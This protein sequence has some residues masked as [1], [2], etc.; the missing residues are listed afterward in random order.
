MNKI[1]VILLLIA[2]VCVI[3][4]LFLRKRTLYSSDQ[5]FIGTNNE[6]Q[7]LMI[8]AHPDDEL[9]FGGRELL[10]K[11]NWK[12]V[13]ITNG[14][15][16]A[17]DKFTLDK[18]NRKKEFIN[19]MNFLKCSY[20][21]WDYEDNLFNANWNTELLL[22]N[23]KRVINEKDYQMILTHNLQGEYGHVQHIMVS[24]LVHQLKPKNLYVFDHDEK[25]KN[26]DCD[27]L[28]KLGRK[29]YSSQV[30]IITKHYKD[31]MHQSIK[32]NI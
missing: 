14:T 11:N 6:P 12:V 8:V 21:I 26:S 2:L 15:S 9:I 29:F 19:I 16:K 10:N 28:C 22:N 13:C 18:T 1:Y 30:D 5:I 24:K 20:E 31:I 17:Q 7:N 23:L 32:K 25:Q 3:V 4:Y 27:L